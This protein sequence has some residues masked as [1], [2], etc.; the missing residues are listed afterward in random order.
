MKTVKDIPSSFMNSENT[1]K[2][3]K[4]LRKIKDWR[5]VRKLIKK[6]ISL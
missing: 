3:E 6:S 1:K 5:E 2:A 4:V